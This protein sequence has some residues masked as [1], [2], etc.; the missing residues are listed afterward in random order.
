MFI[1]VNTYNLD[2]AKINIFRTEEV[3]YII[4]GLI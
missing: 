4:D 1:Y 3:G 2:K